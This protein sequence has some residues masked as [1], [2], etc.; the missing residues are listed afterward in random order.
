MNVRCTFCLESNVY[1]RPIA[2][3]RLVTI[4]GR[5]VLVCNDHMPRKSRM[6]ND[7]ERSSSSY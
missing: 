6:E 1:A 4:N 2:N 3:V 7:N 5:D